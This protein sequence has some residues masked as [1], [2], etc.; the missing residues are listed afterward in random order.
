MGWHWILP[1]FPIRKKGYLGS[2]S[3]LRPSSKLHFGKF[4]DGQRLFGMRRMAHNNDHQD[5][6]HT[7]Q[8]M[9]CGEFQRLLVTVTLLPQ[10]RW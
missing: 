8:V 2:L 1:L 3:M 6:S 5:L 9:Q 7:H 10:S 4:V